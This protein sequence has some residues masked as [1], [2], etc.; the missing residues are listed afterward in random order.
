MTSD[1]L[2]DGGN[3]FNLTPSHL[4]PS[5]QEL[6]PPHSEMVPGGILNICY[7]MTFAS[8][9]NWPYFQ[10]GRSEGKITCGKRRPLCCFSA[11]LQIPKLPQ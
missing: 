11:I 10:H 3:S 1:S 6:D 2:S 5:M 8:F 4:N 9:K 7:F